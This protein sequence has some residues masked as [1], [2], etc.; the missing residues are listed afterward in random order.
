MLSSVGQE[1]SIGIDCGGGQEP[2]LTEALKG[3]IWEKA[4]FLEDCLVCSTEW[5]FL[6]E[7]L[8]TELR[9]FRLLGQRHTAEPHPN[10]PYSRQWGGTTSHTVIM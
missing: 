2:S 10:S 9:A 6:L 8:G 5:N 1:S 7:V 3:H 4:R